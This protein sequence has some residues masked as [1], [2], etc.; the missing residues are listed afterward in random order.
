MARAAAW[1]DGVTGFS[2]GGRGDEMAAT[3]RLAE[4]TWAAAGRPPPRKVSGCF[5]VLGV[6]D[7]GPTLRAFAERYLAIFG[8]ELATALAADTWVSSPDAL[9]QVLDDADAAGCD[10]LI[11]VPG[12]VERACLDAIAEVVAAR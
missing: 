6:E 11:L 12:T 2:I 3:N 5:A 4:E 8:E 10:E 1:A 9:R 7:P